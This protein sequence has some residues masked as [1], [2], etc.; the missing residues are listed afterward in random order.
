[1]RFGWVE[2]CQ[3]NL[4][5]GIED[6]SLLQ[7]ERVTTRAEAAAAERVRHIGERLANARAELRRVRQRGGDIEAAT[8]RVA[9]QRRQW[10][11]WE[12]NER[13]NQ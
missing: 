2:L 9:R 10:E 3:L 1:M 4:A 8:K 6:P 7:E 11:E 5:W 13:V 12:C